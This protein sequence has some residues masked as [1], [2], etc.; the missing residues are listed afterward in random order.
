MLSCFRGPN[1]LSLDCDFQRQVGGRLANP[2]AN[3]GGWAL[4]SVCGLP[5]DPLGV[6]NAS[7]C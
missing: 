3:G 5:D 4:S 2:V 7:L 1:G 6:N